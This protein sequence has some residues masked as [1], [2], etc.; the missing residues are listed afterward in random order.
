MCVEERERERERERGRMREGEEG[1][2]R[3]EVMVRERLCD[4]ERGVVVV[5]GG[6][7]VG[8][9]LGERGLPTLSEQD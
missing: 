2:V 9:V 5:V 4:C 7:G 1:G 6:G 8:G 3:K